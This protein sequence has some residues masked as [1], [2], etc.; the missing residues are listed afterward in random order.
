MVPAGHSV[1][2]GKLIELLQKPS[3]IG[4]TISDEQLTAACGKDTRPGG[5]GYGH[6][7][8]AIN[9]VLKHNQLVWQRVRGAEAIQRLDPDGIADAAKRSSSMICR[10]AKKSVAKLQCVELEKV[11]ESD[12]P[13]FVSLLAQHGALAAFA[14]SDTRKKLEA[15]D[16]PTF[17]PSKL[18][19]AFATK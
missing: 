5:N 12:R 13:K 19:S 3:E 18:L 7:H 14:K 2:T 4:D 15:R 8:T 16:C 17:D 6:L 9:Y 11:E 1:T 10:A